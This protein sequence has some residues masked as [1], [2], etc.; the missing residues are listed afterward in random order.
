ME[1][2][3]LFIIA[4]LVIVIFMLLTKIYLM[5]KSAIEIGSAFEERLAAD[6]NTLID[7]SSR[8]PYMCQLTAAIFCGNSGTST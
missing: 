7:I 4:A 6:T 8:D 1:H 3:L 5:H 2:L